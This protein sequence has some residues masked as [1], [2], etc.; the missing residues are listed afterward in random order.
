MKNKFTKQLLIFTLIIVLS[1]AATYV[2][3]VNG[4]LNFSSTQFIGVSSRLNTAQVKKLFEAENLINDKFYQ[5]PDENKLLEG[6][7]KGMFTALEDEYSDYY[8]PEEFAKLME[9]STGEYEG[10]GVV[11]YANEDKDTVVLQVYEKTPAAEAGMRM[12]DKIVKVD[13]EDVLG[14]GTDYTVSKM[15]GESGTEVEVTFEHDN[16][17][18][19]TKKLKRAKINQDSVSAEMLDS[20]IGYIQ[21]NE[22]TTQTGNQFDEKLTQLEK[23]NINGLIVDLRYNGGGIVD[24]AVHVANRLLGDG[25][26]GYHVDQNGNRIDYDRGD[27]DR[28]NKPVVFLVNEGTAS[29]SEILA[30][31]VQDDGLAKLVGTK[32]FG[33]GVVQEL[34]TFSD[35]SGYKITTETNFTPKG[36]AIHKVGLTPDVNLELSEKPENFF[37]MTHEADNQLQKA[38]EIIRNEKK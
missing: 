19:V 27:G 10:I 20:S 17:E 12:N 2:L 29:A 9:E 30:G 32:T 11:V 4:F 37:T 34:S 13:G 35:G 5:K 7:V 25:E 14:K 24:D 1:N 22:F 23:Q 31:A 28:F 36:H 33:K 6:A 18:Q 26:V 38:I 3:T 15:R 16:G 21:I 8:T